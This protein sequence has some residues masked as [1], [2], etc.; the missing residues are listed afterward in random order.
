MLAAS[1]Q[2]QRRSAAAANSSFCG[3][4]TFKETLFKKGN[5]NRQHFYL[6]LISLLDIVSGTFTTLNSMFGANLNRS[7]AS[8][9][10]W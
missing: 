4:V 9:V 10:R 5:L 8:K 7:A 3:A 1:Y 2:H 6:K